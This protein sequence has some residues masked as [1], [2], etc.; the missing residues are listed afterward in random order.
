LSETYNQV[1]HYAGEV[2]DII[3]SRARSIVSE[4]AVPKTRTFSCS[5][6][7]LCYKVVGFAFFVYVYTVFIFAT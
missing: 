5:F 7:T 3:I 4:I 6:V 2:K 1:G